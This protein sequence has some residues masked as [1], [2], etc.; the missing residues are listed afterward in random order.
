MT[1][2]A[3]LR[4]AEMTDLRT[5]L[6]SARRPILVG[7]AGD[8]GSGKTT[9]T[10]GIRR[11][12]G[13]DMVTSIPLDGYHRENRAQRRR[14][15]RLPLDPANNH[16]DLVKE[17]L[18]ALRAGKPVEVP[19]YNHQTG[20]FDAPQ[21]VRPAPVVV[22]EGLHALYEHLRPLLDFTLYVDAD[23][24]VKW[25]WK[26]ERDVSYRGHDPSELEDEIRRREAA[27][28]QWIDFQKTSA[29][30]VVKIH[31]SNLEQLAHQRNDGGLPE[32]CYHMEIVIAAT[33][34]PLPALTLPVNL[35]A[36]MEADS[37]PFMLS[38]VRSRYWGK[39]VNV[40][41]IDGVIP[42]EAMQRLEEEIMRLT[43]ISR[44]LDLC[45]VNNAAQNSTMRLAQ[46]LVAWPFLG[47]VRALLQEWQAED[48]A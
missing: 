8:S 1:Q 38:A 26:F 42:L 7:V 46:S 15:G 3:Y 30:L 14:S 40:A 6:D 41:H 20:C 28:K 25:R 22:I 36:A 17:H 27:Y 35:N 19:I 10:Q 45:L 18:R 31:E 4:A 5:M 29:D 37:R 39:R 32:N 23:R 24:D 16:L 11:L 33:Q 34:L 9:Y 21:I 47:K 48:Q 2:P 13:N 12:L 44:D 43:G